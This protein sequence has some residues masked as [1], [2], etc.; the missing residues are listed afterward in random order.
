[1]EVTFEKNGSL[2]ASLKISLTPADYTPAVEAELK[3]VQKKA[4]APGFRPGHV[5][6]GMVKKMY[7]KEIY[8]DEVN[9]L[10]SQ[11][12]YGYLEENKINYLAQPLINENE[13]F[14]ADFDKQEDFVFVFEMGLAPEVSLDLSEKD[15][16]TQYK[17][18]VDDALIEKEIE[19]I[20]KRYAERVVVDSSES[21]DIVYLIATELDENGQPLEGGLTEK[22]ISVTPEMI[23]DAKLQKQLLGLKMGDT[24]TA[25]IFTLFNDNETA[26]SASLGIQ[27]EGVADLNK[28]FSFIVKEVVRMTPAEMNTQLFDQV[29][30]EGR[31]ENEESFRQLL[32]EDLENYY[33][34]EA[35][36]MFEHAVDHLIT[37][38]HN[39]E[40]PEKFLKRWLLQE[41]KGEI[42]PENVDEQY[43][44]E[45]KSLRYTLLRQHILEENQV[46]ITPEEVEQ[47]NMSHSAQM[48]RQYGLPADYDLIKRFADQNA[49]D[50]EHI[51]RMYESVSQG[52]FMQIA[53]SKV[54]AV[55]KEV[56][57]E[58]FYDI[59]K[60]HNEEHHH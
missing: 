37:D 55:E 27:K 35:N 12:L 47:M 34:S 41:S 6:M 52:K 29:F 15:K 31:A 9:K 30:G 44:K 7:G 1:M 48:L 10:V 2:E 39:F 25:S 23:K 17:I 4:S 46:D 36:H 26:I 54:K 5:P 40:L 18:K 38:K 28:T 21:A 14:K 43:E 33:A 60:K 57:V 11:A 20:R 56:S 24:F 8:A 16:V 58:E 59:I 19:S 49:K 3:K 50:K 13:D 51:R 45:A 42:T 53:K 22:E 32:R